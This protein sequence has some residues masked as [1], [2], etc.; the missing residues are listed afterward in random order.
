MARII[1]QVNAVNQ[2]LLS[3]DVMKKDDEALGEDGRATQGIDLSE[4]SQDAGANQNWELQYD[5][6]TEDAWRYSPEKGNVVF[7]SA[8]HCWSFRVN[9]FARLVA[10]KM[11]A[12]PRMLQKA[13]WGDWAFSAKTKSAVRRSPNDSKTKP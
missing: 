3:E 4:E 7:T 8:S 1:E 9:T 11:G 2:Q 6:V 12:N 13:L 5:D 10:G